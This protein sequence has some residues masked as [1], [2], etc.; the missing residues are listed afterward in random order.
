MQLK[1]GVV[2]RRAYLLVLFLSFSLCIAQSAPESI[3]AFGIDLYRFL[4]GSSENIFFSPFSLSTALAMTYLGADGNTA[5][6][7]RKV[8][9]FEDEG[10]HESFSNLI[11]SLNKPAEDYKLSIA[12]ALWLQE[13]YPLLESFLAAV[14]K[15]YRAPVNSVDFVNDPKNSVRRIND[16]IEQK[17]EGKIKDMI[18]EDDVDSL[19]RLIITNA[20]Y[21]KGNWVVSFDPQATKKDVFFVS[22]D[23]TVE[24]DM[25]KL[26]ADFNY[27]ED[28]KVQ[29]LELPYAGG[30]LSMIVVLPKRGVRLSEVEKDLSLEK[31]QGWL[32]NL[33][34]RRVEVMLPRFKVMQRFSLKKTL[35][36]MGMV[37]AFTNAADFSKM[38]GTKILKIQN[39]IHQA[40]VEVNEEG[41]EAAAAT[42]VIIGIKMGPNMPVVFRADKPFLFFI[43]EKNNGVIL[44]MGRLQKP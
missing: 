16:W 34:N 12:N 35:S 36:E 15:Y 41:T 11:D 14:E 26:T 43:Y 13:G 6:Q 42:G 5:L 20:I 3:N 25:M 39:V 8:L 1:G 44:F 2:V 7:M 4:A 33:R 18:N 10:L 19:T 40:F 29:I 17:T 30:N 22:E 32:R 37:D 28:E 38:D 27:F 23:K 21:F 31:F 24:V 9:H